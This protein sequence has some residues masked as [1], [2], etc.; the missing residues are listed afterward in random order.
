MTTFLVVKTG[1]SGATKDQLH[2][3][4]VELA[5]GTHTRLYNQ[6]LSGDT[7]MAIEHYCRQQGITGTLSVLAFADAVADE[8]ATEQ[9]RVYIKLRYGIDWI[10]VAKFKREGSPESWDCEQDYEQARDGAYDTLAERNVIRMTS[11]TTYTFKRENKQYIKDFIAQAMLP[12]IEKN[13]V[14]L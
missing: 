14:M 9:Q 1:K 12:V 4:I 7:R 6:H 2:N 11:K 3:T 10:V 8:M 5:D 13:I